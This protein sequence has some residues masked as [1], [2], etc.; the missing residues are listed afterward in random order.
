MALFGLNWLVTRHSHRRRTSALWSCNPCSQS[1]HHHPDPDIFCRHL[2]APSS[3]LSVFHSRLQPVPNH[4][5]KQRFERYVFPIRSRINSIQQLLTPFCISK[6]KSWLPIVQRVNA[7]TCTRTMTAMSR[8]STVARFAWG[9]NIQWD[10]QAR[11]NIAAQIPS[12]TLNAYLDRPT[13]E[14]SEEQTESKNLQ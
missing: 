1:F 4:S 2:S 14:K 7:F 3:E 12:A 11:S 6:A 13:Q 5:K 9:K 8:S 10:W